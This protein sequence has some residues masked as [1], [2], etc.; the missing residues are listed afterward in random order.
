VV[1]SAD[2]SAKALVVC[3]RFMD[4]FPQCVCCQ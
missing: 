2:A 1:K 4:L 3:E